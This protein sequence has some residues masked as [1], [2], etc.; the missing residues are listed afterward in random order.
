MTRQVFA[1]SALA[2]FVVASCATSKSPEERAAETR[3]ADTKTVTDTKSTEG[4]AE[5]V[6]EKTMGKSEFVVM[7]TNHGEVE[8]ELFSDK[9]PLSVANFLSYVDDKFYDQTVFHRVIPKFMVQ[10]GG[11]STTYDKKETKAPIK[12]EATNGLKNDVGTLAMA[13]TG[14]VDS[15]TAQFFIN[16][17][18][19]GFLNHTAP[20]PR[21]YG[22]AVFGKVVKGMDVVQKIEQVQTGACKGFAKDCPQESVVIESI[23]RR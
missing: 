1:F 5:K 15:A 2:V 6:A 16:T 13:R 14:I 3:P 11:F 20:N 22:Y 21:G 9:A 10:G 12:N 19:N 7:K 18:D 23:R 8:I 17:K 4:A